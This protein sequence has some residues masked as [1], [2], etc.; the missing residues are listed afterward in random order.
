MNTEDIWS[1][2]ITIIFMR[3]SKYLNTKLHNIPA[4]YILSTEG[5]CE[6]QKTLPTKCY[7]NRLVL[8]RQ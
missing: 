5:L 1:T 3:S 7:L 4:S 8:R 6:A 2:Y